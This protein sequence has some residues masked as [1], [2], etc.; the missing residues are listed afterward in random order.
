MTLATLLASLGPSTAHASGAAPTDSEKRD[1]IGQEERALLRQGSECFLR[2]DYEGARIALLRAYALHPRADTVVQL[3]MAELQSGHPVEAAAHLREFLTHTEEP[4]SK[5]EPIRTKW[6]PRAEAATSR[7]EIFAPPGAQVLVD[8]AIREPSTASTPEGVRAGGP[9]VFVV[10]AAGEHDVSARQGTFVE[11]QHVTVNGGQHLELHFQ[12]VPDVPA[13]PSPTGK[14]LPRESASPA[15]GSEAR[16]R[17]RWVMTLALGSAALAAT[18]VAI[19]FSIAFEHNAS[20]ARG[21]RAQIGNPQNAGCP[22]P[23]AMCSTLWQVDDAQER[24]GALATGFYVA[25]GVAGG[26]AAASWFLWPQ[27]KDSGLHPSPMV[28]AG[29]AGVALHGTW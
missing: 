24:N 13:S 7:L 29:R 3:G 5:L 18:G 28:G 8:G 14:A 27:A 25:G 20:D 10:V 11:Q 1:D 26:L 2:Q 17:A 6:L 22:T 16:A 15:S 21:L 23:T 19:G 12:R 9:S 4:A